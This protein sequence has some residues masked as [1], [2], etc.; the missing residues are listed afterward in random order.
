[1]IKLVK[2]NY[3]PYN[4]FHGLNIKKVK[5]LKTY[6]EIYDKTRFLLF[7]ISPIDNLIFL[8]K[9]LMIVFVYILNSKI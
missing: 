3:P 6:I 1:M 5:S 9:S 7:F 4:L 8:I 2:H